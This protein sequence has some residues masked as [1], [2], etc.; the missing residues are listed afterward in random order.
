M[1]Y[2][3]LPAVAAVAMVVLSFIRRDQPRPA[4]P[5]FGVGLYWAGLVVLGVYTAFWFFFGFGELFG[6]I[7][8]GWIHLFPAI[9][10]ALLLWFSR[11][12]PL[13]GGITLALLGLLLGMYTLASMGASSKTLLPSLLFTAAPSLAAGLLLMAACATTIPNTKPKA[14]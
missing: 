8:G 9:A 5:P 11:K 12:L 7:Q 13:E 2:L 4:F 1:V 3:I 6:N 10:S 14:G